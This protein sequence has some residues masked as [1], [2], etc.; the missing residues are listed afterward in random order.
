M[1]YDIT[2]ALDHLHQK[3][4][5]HCDIKTNNVLVCKKK[6]YLIDFGKVRKTENLIG[7]KYSSIYSHI[8][9]EVLTGH[10][11]S[12]ASDVYSLGKVIGTIGKAIQN[13]FLLSIGNLS[14]NPNACK[15]PTLLRLLT[16]FQPH[17]TK[18]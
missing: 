6:G 8:A 4:Y 16:D 17:M 12:K 18:T 3:G 10:P 9:P 5:L 2:D 15:R 11:P 13:E 14:I 7:K 1:C